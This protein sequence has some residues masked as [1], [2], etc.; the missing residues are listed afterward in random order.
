MITWGKQHYPIILLLFQEIKGRIEL[1]R[2]QSM[3]KLVKEW[4]IER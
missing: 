1:F 3:E 4:I 2:G